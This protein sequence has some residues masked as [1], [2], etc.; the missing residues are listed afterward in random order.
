M[1]LYLP[2]RSTDCAE[3]PVAANAAARPAVKDSI[4]MKITPLDKLNQTLCMI[5]C[6]PAID[7]KAA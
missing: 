3:A 5:P 6:I 2:E 1:Q 4:L 7:I